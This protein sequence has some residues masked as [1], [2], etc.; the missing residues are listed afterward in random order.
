MI[1][2]ISALLLALLLGVA[3]VLPGCDSGGP[4]A[5]APGSAAGTVKP[6]SAGGASPTPL[7]PRSKKAKSAPGPLPL[8]M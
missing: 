8:P 6:V 7:L 4:V 2:P 1:R 5:V 3:T